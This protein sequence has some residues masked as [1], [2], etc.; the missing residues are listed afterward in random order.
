[1]SPWQKLLNRWW[2]RVRVGVE[3]VIGTLKRH[4]GMDRM[5]YIGRQRNW[6]HLTLVGIGYNL[7]R[8]LVLQGLA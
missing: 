7:K 1:L 2:A 3:R 8:M 5:R 4:Y 6:F